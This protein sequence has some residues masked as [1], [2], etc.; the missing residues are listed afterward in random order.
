MCKISVIIPVYNGETYLAQCLD[1]IIGQTLKEIEIICVNDGSKDRTQQILEKYA[2]KD[3]R[4]QIISQ[5][6]GGARR[7]EMQDFALQEENIY[8]FWMETISLNRICWK[9]HI[10]KQEKVGQ[11]FWCLDQINTTKQPASTKV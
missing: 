4:I 2:E 6:N 5:E 3:S 11:S 10:K 9:K 1:S 8:P 7:R